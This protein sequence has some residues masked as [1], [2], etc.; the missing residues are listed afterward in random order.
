[1]KPF[2]WTPDEDAILRAMH[3]TKTE[4][5]ISAAVGRSVSS[6]RQ[7]EWRLRL[8]KKPVWSKKDLGILRVQWGEI[9]LA[10]LAAQLGRTPYA[11]YQRGVADGLPAGCPRHHEYLYQAA[12]RVGVALPTLRNV[13]KWARVPVRAAFS[14]PGVGERCKRYTVERFEVDRAVER[15]LKF[16]KPGAAARVRGVSPTLVRERLRIV[17][18]LKPPGKGRHWLVPSETIDAVLASHPSQRAREARRAA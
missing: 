18:G 16:E 15:W 17:C 7:R 14:Y 9:P 1:M 10:E 2:R 12:K 13:L 3:G 6:V 11:V 4:Q 5:E 8:L